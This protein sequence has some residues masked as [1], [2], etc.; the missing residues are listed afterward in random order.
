MH[1]T[2]YEYPVYR[3]VRLRDRLAIVPEIA[4]RLYI[5]LVWLRFAATKFESGWLTTN[6]L[7]ALLTSVAAGQL[8]TTVPG[9]HIIAQLLV[10]THADALL[11]VLI[12]FTEL[13]LGI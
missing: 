10:I 7:R 9:Y 12:P 5:A 3:G 11:S 2:T 4:L 1:S 6:P 8:P 13:A